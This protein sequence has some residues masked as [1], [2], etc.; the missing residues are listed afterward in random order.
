MTNYLVFVLHVVNT[1][2]T[3]LNIFGLE[4]K[5]CTG[6]WACMFFIFE[7]T[8]LVYMQ[9]VYFEAQELIDGESCMAS[10][11]KLYFMLMG[12]ILVFYAGTVVVVCYFFRQHCQD[13]SL[14]EK[15]AKE[16]AERKAAFDEEKT[17]E[18]EGNKR[19]SGATATTEG[20]PTPPG[21]LSTKIN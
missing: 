21:K 16:E 12:N 14:I 11:P 6:F 4:K 2:E 7:C 8:V 20:G 3:L 17:N 13:P 18:E 5:L 1:G 10:F 19:T 9:V 15:E